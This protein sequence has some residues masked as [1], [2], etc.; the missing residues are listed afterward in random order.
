MENFMYVRR[1]YYPLVMT[2]TFQRVEALVIL[3]FLNFV[4]TIF[5]MDIVVDR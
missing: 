3:G 5:I 2:K 4:F 1:L